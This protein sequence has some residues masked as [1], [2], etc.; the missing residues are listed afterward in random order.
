[1]SFLQA[2]CPSC[3][4]IVEFKSGAS[5]VVVCPYCRSAVARTDRG[6]EDLGKVAEIAG[7]ESPLKLGLKGTFNDTR[8]ELTGRAQYKH[9]QGGS[10]D[11]WY[12]TFNNG[13]VGWL[14]EAQGNFY[15]TF[16]QPVPK[17]VTLPTFDQLQVGGAIPAVPGAPELLVQE[18]S[19]ATATAAEGEIPYEFSPGENSQ[20]ADLVGKNGAFGTLDF[21]FSPPWLFVGKQVTLAEIG[22]SDARPA[23]REAKRVASQGMGCPKCGGPLELSV[24]DQA[25]RITCPFC[26]SLLDVNQGK[27]SFFKAL[28]KPNNEPNFLLE[29]GSE[30]TFGDDKYKIIGAMSRYVMFDGIKYFWH[31]Y[32][33]YNPKIGFRWL[34][35]SD[36][37]WSFVEAVNLADIESGA[38]AS[39]VPM[40]VSYN[41]KYFKIFQNTTAYVD[42]VKG[43][44][45]WRVEQGQTVLATDY[46]K[47]PLM[48]SKE[49][50]AGEVNWSLGSYLT[51]DKVEKAFGVSGLPTPKGVAPNQPFTGSFY[52]TAG[53]LPIVVLFV[54]AVFMI[55]L[56]GMSKTVL[57]EKVTFEP[58]TP[59]IPTPLTATPPTAPPASKVKFS[60]PFELKGNSNVRITASAAVDNSAVDMDIDL[61]NEQNQEVESASIPVSYY[62]GVEGGESWS[63][64]GK[65]NDATFSS[66]PA[67]KYTLRVDGT[68]EAAKSPV[69]VDL[70]VEQNVTRGVNFICAL[71][72]LLIFPVLGLLKKF[73][74]ESRR[75]A[76]SEFGPSNSE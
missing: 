61:I 37:H 46:V 13:W 70:K 67:G 44:F 43:E 26:N 66:L 33:L 51:K 23:E 7:S 39:Q 29:I 63:E 56:T 47:A 34:V 25:E 31:E 65:S 30:G 18:A 59:L 48:L 4:G 24:P 76:D 68:L 11:E 69:V 1:M 75:W 41:G 45:Y 52:Y 10:W 60:S 3:G 15:I 9:S 20:F 28:K 62:H 55:P 14:A 54:V 53:L 19:T 71:L 8:F 21:S 38:G 72:L 36:E 50:T 35:Q 32:L 5:I 42:Y 57:S 64:G 40:S 74:F 17:S 16:F 73:S 6:L 58:T 27:L 12:A 2:N 22:L 49:S